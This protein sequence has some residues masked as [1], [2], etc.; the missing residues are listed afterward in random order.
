[1]ELLLNCTY[2]HVCI[3][4]MKFP[5]VMRWTTHCHPYIHS[6]TVLC[7]MYGLLQLGQSGGPYVQVIC[8]ISFVQNRKQFNLVIILCELSL[9]VYKTRILIVQFLNHAVQKIHVYIHV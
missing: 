6:T 5:Y 8:M 9:M 2:I 1:M 7:D 4:K 3:K